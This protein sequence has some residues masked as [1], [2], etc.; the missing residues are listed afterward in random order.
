MRGLP[1][2]GGSDLNG[3]RT[4]YGFMTTAFTLIGSYLIVFVPTF[5]AFVST[6]RQLAILRSPDVPI[7]FTP[8]QFPEAL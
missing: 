2:R 3:R 5:G 7:E 4:R 8:R 1:A 6:L